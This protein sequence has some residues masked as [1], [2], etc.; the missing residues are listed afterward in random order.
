MKK[1]GG[2]ICDNCRSLFFPGDRIYE[3]CNRCATT[4]YCIF[5]NYKDGTKELFAVF[6]NKEQAEQEIEQRK[7]K[8]GILNNLVE[9]KIINQEVVAYHTF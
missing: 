1:I 7:S 8:L 9:N 3:F 4:V 6:R 2:K 5:N